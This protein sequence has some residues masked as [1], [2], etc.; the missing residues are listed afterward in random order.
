M[1]ADFLSFFWHIGYEKTILK[2]RK[3]Q[4]TTDVRIA[5]QTIQQKRQMIGDAAHH[6]T[7]RSTD[8]RF[9]SALQRRPFGDERRLTACNDPSAGHSSDGG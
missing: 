8:A 1:T 3:I 2:L 7:G 5:T 9:Y 4:L 6:T